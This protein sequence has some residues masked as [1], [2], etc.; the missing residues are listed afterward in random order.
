VFRGLI[1]AGLLALCLTLAAHTPVLGADPSLG[2]TPGASPVIIDP[3][4]PR[5]GE[6]ANRVGAPFLALVVVV[7]LGITTAAATVVYVRLARRA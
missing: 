4:D 6:G 2:A 7:F 3:L 1:A 5:A